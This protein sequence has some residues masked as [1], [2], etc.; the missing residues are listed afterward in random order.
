MTPHIYHERAFHR[1]NIKLRPNSSVVYRLPT[2]ENIFA[3][4]SNYPRQHR[5]VYSTKTFD[6]EWPGTSGHKIE[7]LSNDWV[8]DLLSHRL[9]GQPLVFPCNNVRHLRR[10]H[11]QQCQTI[12]LITAKFCMEPAWLVGT[13]SSL[14]QLGHMAN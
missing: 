4:L 13:K 11:R 9:I 5:G 1:T 14:R 12:W 7:I 8:A 6:T 3:P 10:S 2:V